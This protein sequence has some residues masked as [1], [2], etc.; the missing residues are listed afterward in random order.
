M[1]VLLIT[2]DPTI[3]SPGSSGHARAKENAV[4]IG[5]LHALVVA[6]QAANRDEGSLR[7]HALHPHPLFVESSLER[8]A[9]KIITQ[10]KI[11]AVWAQDPFERGVMAARVARAFQLPLFVNVEV[12]F[13]SPWFSERTGM[14]RSPK[15]R[16]SPKNRTR[17][18]RARAV[19]EQ[20]AGIRVMSERVKA[21]LLKEYGDRIPEPVVIPIAVHTTL[22]EPVA[23]PAPLFPFRLMVAGRLDAGRRVEDVIA[24][25]AKIKDTYPGVGLYVVGDGP[26]R[27]SLEQLARRLGLK[28]RVLFLG[29]RPDVRGLMRSAHVYIQASAHEGYGRRLLQAALARIPII[30]TDVGIVGE[31]FKG[32][33]DVLAMPPGDPAAL[34]VHIVGL[35]HDGSARQLLAMNAE[36]AAKRFLQEAGD[37][38]ARIVAFLRASAAEK[39]SAA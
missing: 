15:V 7:I 1:K 11:D 34:A 12:D 39:P 27:A 23:F 26:S 4:A 35:V 16:V 32:Y 30:T 31:V 37:V 5:E 3:L 25:L 14:F 18:K 13:L 6:N 36:A 21:S 2:N 8:A 9:R 19:L 33:N 29:D 24:A 22:A 28:D 38:P 20:A 17:R 10:Y